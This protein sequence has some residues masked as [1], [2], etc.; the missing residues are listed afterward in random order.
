MTCHYTTTRK[1]TISKLTRLNVNKDQE[2]LEFS[3]IANE[4]AKHRAILK[5]W[6]FLIKLNI[7]LPYDREIPLLSVNPRE[8]KTYVH[9][10]T[11]WQIFLAAL[12]IKWSQ[13][14]KNP[15]IHEM[16]NRRANCSIRIISSSTKRTKPLINPTTT[17]MDL[18]VF[19]LS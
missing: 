19:P 16:I 11:Y 13:A 1:V 8:K 5:V 7:H 18:Q 3:C 14:R 15:N 2:H 6:Q 9:T 10:N 12:I 17:W 4:K